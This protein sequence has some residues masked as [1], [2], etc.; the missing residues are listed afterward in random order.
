MWLGSRRES[1]TVTRALG[2][3]TAGGSARG[4]ASA[5]PHPCPGAGGGRGQASVPRT[6]LRG[7]WRAPGDPGSLWPDLPSRAHCVR[8]W[9]RSCVAAH[10]CYLTVPPMTRARV[11]WHIHAPGLK[12]GGMTPSW[13]RHA[14]RGWREAAGGG[15]VP[16]AGGP[17]LRV[18]AA[19]CRSL[20]AT[21]RPCRHPRVTSSPLGPQ[22]P[23][24]ST[25]GLAQPRVSPFCNTAPLPLAAEP[26]LP[27]PGPVGRGGGGGRRESGANV[28]ILEARAGL[29][30]GRGCRVA[31]WWN[32]FPAAW[33][34]PVPVYLR[35]GPRPASARSRPTRP[36]WQDSGPCSPACCST[37]RASCNGPRTG[38]R[39]AWARASKVS[40]LPPPPPQ[41]PA[42]P[43]LVPRPQHTLL[44]G[45]P[46]LAPLRVPSPASARAMS[47]QRPK[48]YFG[49]SL[50]THF[51][52]HSG[53]HSR[54]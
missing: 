7:S 32:P 29:Q 43:F 38:W 9:G 23:A 31:A 37:T 2:S 18:E 12:G 13:T 48:T 50:G 39:W 28:C 24:C 51:P 11:L 16:G 5:C 8:P 46:S 30:W 47:A 14:S 33:P 44:G 6:G 54:C 34:Y 19:L 27:K 15:P 17:S 1:G 22:C 49:V 3:P 40:G 36:W 20:P 42:S 25:R 26:R 35:Q 41:H 10:V 21:P 53:R 4:A 52:T 45:H